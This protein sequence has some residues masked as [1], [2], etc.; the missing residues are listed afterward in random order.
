MKKILA[1][2][3]ALMMLFAMTGC[4]RTERKITIHIADYGCDF[5][6]SEIAADGASNWQGR[7]ISIVYCDDF[8]EFSTGSES[9]YPE[10]I[11]TKTAEGKYKLGDT[12]EDI[13]VHVYVTETARRALPAKDSFISEEKEDDLVG[14]VGIFEYPIRYGIPTPAYAFALKDDLSDLSTRIDRLVYSDD[15]W[16]VCIKP[17]EFN[18]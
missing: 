16:I 2:L 10:G 1:L 7:T 3:L 15:L 6:K 11:E 9:G 17:D 4:D 12:I 8:T 14:H 13:L 18:K 5:E